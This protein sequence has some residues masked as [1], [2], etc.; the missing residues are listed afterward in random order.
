LLLL[1][2]ENRVLHRIVL[3]YLVDKLDIGPTLTELKN[4]SKLMDPNL[5]GLSIS[6]SDKIRFE[7]NKF[8]SP[9]P[10]DFGKRQATKK[11]DDVFHFVT[12]LHFKKNIYEI[13]GLQEG[14]ILINEEV[15]RKDWIER[16]KPA[17]IQRINLYSLNEI[18]FNLLAVVPDRREICLEQNMLLENQKKF[19]LKKLSEGNNQ[20]SSVDIEMTESFPE[21]EGK[22]VNELNGKLHEIELKLK[23]NAETITN[24]NEKSEKN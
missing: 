1:G 12:Y 24:E 10:F 23:L 22:S 14:P 16:V 3:V 20:S 2:G 11:D 4:F 13:D 19:V 6:N 17:I 8:A 15:E 9:E 21:L 18:K 5:K 7:H